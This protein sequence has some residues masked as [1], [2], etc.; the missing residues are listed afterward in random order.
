MPA[1]LDLRDGLEPDRPLIARRRHAKLGDGLKRLDIGDEFLEG[2]RQPALQPAG[3][4]DQHRGAGKHGTPEAELRFIGR[5]G[6]RNIGSAAAAGPPGQADM[7][8]K[9]TRAQGRLDMLGRSEG[10]VNC[11]SVM[12]ASASAC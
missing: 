5:L 6:I 1:R 7:P 8:G 11:A 12:P 4:M 9:L 3:G 10:R 2:I